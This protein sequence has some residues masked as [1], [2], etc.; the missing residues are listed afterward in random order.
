MNLSNK[1]VLNRVKDIFSLID[2]A[3]SIDDL[4]KIQ[5]EFSPKEI[6]DNFPSGKYPKLKFS[7]SNEDIEQLKTDGI[8]NQDGT[9][10]KLC[11][12]ADKLKKNLTPLEKLLYSVLWKNG[13]LG[14]EKHITDGILENRDSKYIKGET[15]LVFY[16]FGQ[17]LKD[18]KKPIIDQHVIRAFKLY[19]A[20]NDGVED[21]D[22]I[23]KM[24]TLNSKDKDTCLSYIKWQNEHKL[25]ASNP[26]EFTYHLDRLL[27]GLGKSLKKT[28]S[29]KATF[30]A[31]PP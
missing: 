28:V 16:Y 12:D 18:K 3:N 23:L 29:S 6:K 26:I 21:I 22:K 31:I 25:K 11:A 24:D 30:E 8:L 14:K 17:H 27:F 13:D 7:L 5:N 10:S 2:K 15:G 20:L 9:I 1:N 19:Q 4:E